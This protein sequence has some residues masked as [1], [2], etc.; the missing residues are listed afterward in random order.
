[1]SSSS[2]SN[3]HS[4]PGRD[5]NGVALLRKI[6]NM[7]NRRE[8]ADEPLCKASTNIYDVPPTTQRIPPRRH[9]PKGR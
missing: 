3:S 4:H 6:L 1:M 5:S 9:H 7:Q 8:H 2:H